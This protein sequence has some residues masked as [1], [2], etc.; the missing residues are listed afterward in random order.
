MPRFIRVG[1][2]PQNDNPSNP[3]VAFYDVSAT[4]GKEGKGIVLRFDSWEDCISSLQEALDRAKEQKHLE[5]HSMAFPMPDI[6]PAVTVSA[7]T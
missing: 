1:C 7:K 4:V 5:G 6:R 3:I 2:L